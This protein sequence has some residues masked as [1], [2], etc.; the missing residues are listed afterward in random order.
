[1]EQEKLSRP[2]PLGLLYIKTVE[3]CGMSSI[4][5]LS[6]CAFNLFVASPVLL[7]DV[8]GV[9]GPLAF[10]VELN[11]TCQAIILHL[12]KTLKRERERE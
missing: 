9:I 2:G 4:R 12:I 11:S 5:Y 7:Q 8:E 10:T 1:M 6:K 3:V